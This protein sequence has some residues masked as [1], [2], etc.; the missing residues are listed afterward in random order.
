MNKKKLFC[1]ITVCMVV[2]AVAVYGGRVENEK[3]AKTYS[4]ARELVMH[5]VTLEEAKTVCADI[6]AVVLDAPAKMISVVTKVNNESKYGHPI[7]E[8]SDAAIKQVHAAAGGMVLAS[9]W[10][11]EIGLYI[12]IRHEDA[13]TVYGNL[14]DI[15]VVEKERVQRGEIIG[16][17]DTEGE[18]EFYYELRENL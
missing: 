14:N 12:K 6:S 13:V 8:K 7:D 4:R 10:D 5:Q 16:N 3:F 18:K 1:Q 2:T 15:G 9:G 17:F 11:K